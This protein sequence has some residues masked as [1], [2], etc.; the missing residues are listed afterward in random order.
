MPRRVFDV[1][2]DGEGWK[3]S[4]RTGQLASKHFD[5]KAEAVEFGRAAAQQVEPS[6]LVIRKNDG[7]I[8]TEYTYGSDPFPPRG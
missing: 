2:P 7:K 4:D 5:Q 3:V 8:E 1:A 6:Q